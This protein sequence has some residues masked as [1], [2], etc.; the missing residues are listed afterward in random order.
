MVSFGLN[1]SI[2]KTEEIRFISQG[3]Q[4]SGTFVISEVKPAK[5]A[6][7]FVHGSGPQTRSIRLAQNFAEVGIAALV[8]DKRGVGQSGG[9][10][11]SKQ[12]VSGPNIDILAEDAAAAL[13]FLANHRLTK[14]LP[15]GLT[16]ISQA[17]WI[18]PLAA[19]KSGKANFI[20]LW[21]GPVSKVSEEDIYSKYTRDK[22]SR[23]LPSFDEAL[24]ARKEPYVWPEFLGRDADP[25]ENLV[26]LNIPGFWIFGAKDGSIPVD[27]SIQ[28]LQ[29]LRQKG[30]AYEYVVFS[31]LGHNNIPQT[32]ATAVD[33]VDRIAVANHQSK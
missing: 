24:N 5:A 21:S 20:L 28:R 11:E 17:G 13:D 3:V 19:Q 32:F 14:D 27:L 10:Y 16:G 15:L 1:A 9:E 25:S 7:V 33:W 12:S 29:S 6:V 31:E 18:V 4:L 2:T 23:D 26:T 30:F 22:D 8:Y